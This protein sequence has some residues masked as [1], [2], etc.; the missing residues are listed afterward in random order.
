MKLEEF[1]DRYEKASALHLSRAP[2]IMDEM[3]TVLAES[4][5]RII[6]LENQI[7]A[8]RDHDE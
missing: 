1:I 5:R 2:S 4:A 7:K 3:I 8:M 6:A